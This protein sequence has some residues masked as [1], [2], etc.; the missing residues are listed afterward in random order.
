MAPSFIVDGTLD[1][2]RGAWAVKLHG[3][4]GERDSAEMGL[5]CLVFMT[6][7]RSV[8]LFIRA[9]RVQMGRPF[10][11]PAAHLLADTGT[12]AVIERQIVSSA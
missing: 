9:R 7:P 8:F 6:W 3:K 4:K 12:I 1:G 10:V 5:K 11:V 2:R